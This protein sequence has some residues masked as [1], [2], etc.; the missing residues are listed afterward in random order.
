MR[1]RELAMIPRDLSSYPSA[2]SFF[3]DLAARIAIEPFNLF[4]LIIFACAILHTF[5]APTIK[6][7]AQSL[8]R[9]HKR[10]IG[11]TFRYEIIQFLG[12]VEVVFGFWTI[13]L[14]IGMTGYFGFEGTRSFVGNL[15][16][17][18]PLFIAVV[19]CIAATA[20]VSALFE[21]LVT[22]IARPLGSS[23]KAL[24][25]SALT[26]GPWLGSFITEPAAIAMTAIFLVRTF[27]SRNPPQ[28]LRYAT[29]ALLF[30]NTSLGGIIT[31]FAGHAIVIVAAKWGWNTSYMLVHF[32]WRAA[33]LILFNTWIMS[34][35]LRRHFAK[36]KGSR[37]RPV[38]LTWWVSLVHVL[39]LSWVLCNPLYPA[40]FIGGFFLFLAFYR[41]TKPH[42][43]AINL[44]APLLVCF[45][46]GG[47]IVHVSLQGWWI[48]PLL[49]RLSHFELMSMA[50]IL[51]AFNDN[52]TVTTLGK[53]A[54]ALSQIGRHAIVF[55]A[56]CGGGLTLMANAPNPV[57]QALLS[58]Y[59]N[60]GIV[61]PWRIFI[62]AL[63]FS[64]LAL[65]FFALSLSLS[66]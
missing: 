29:L 16:F 8:G 64:L 1:C 24:W 26:I 2:P 30:V 46:L 55:G 57:A 41:A 66:L 49:T 31:S 25:A 21:W 36:L 34:F 35:C 20:P 32:G 58:R 19:M 38:K 59:F 39:L 48:E 62:A 54:G 53:L 44:R 14:L 18:E 42:Q 40:L 45:F 3:L 9:G 50:S 61:S 65:A 47:L 43:E 6:T 60:G 37:Q 27:Y 15:H 7:F 52:A 28:I 12:E 5:F 33:L 56:A 22:Q 11:K 4:A 63:P 17:T 13:P 23:P 10:A 51:T